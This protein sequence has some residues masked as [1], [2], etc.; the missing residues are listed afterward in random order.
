[1]PEKI[2]SVCNK[3]KP[4]EDFYK[5]A[6]VKDGRMR[7]CKLCHCAVTAKY[8]TQNPEVY[9]KASLKHWH[10]LKDSKKHGKWLKR[11][12]LTKEEYETFFDKQ[13]GLCFICKKECSSGQNLSVDHCHK[14]GKVR[15][16]LCKKCNTA[17]GM[18]EDNIEYF[19][20]AILYL[21]SYEESP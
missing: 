5:E 6:R 7:R 10:N 14:T 15:G 1:M 9:R 2:C 8:R 19:Q 21:K 11:Y 17:L 4:L 16:L 3:L 20:T 18:L 12:G 13:K